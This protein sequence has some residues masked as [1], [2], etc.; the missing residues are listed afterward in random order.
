MSQE[1]LTISLFK[2]DMPFPPI[3]NIPINK[4][5]SL[6]VEIAGYGEEFP[7]IL[8]IELFDTRKILKVR[9]SI[10]IINETNYDFR[11]LFSRYL[12]SEEIV[13]KSRGKSSVPVDYV[14]HL[15]GFIPTHLSCSD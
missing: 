12:E 4:V 5:Q 7:I 8:E 6:A 3:N 9:S 10:L 11:I 15:I 13:C 1:F 2:Y 14:K